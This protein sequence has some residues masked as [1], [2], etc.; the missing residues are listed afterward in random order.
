MDMVT[1]VIV[2]VIGLVV[3]IAIGAGTPWLLK[4]RQGYPFEAQIET[5]LTEYAVTAIAV[6]Y[7]MSEKTMDELGHRLAGVDKKA[8]A[9]AI[10]DML[11]P[12]IGGIPIVVVKAIVTRERFG[13]LVQNAF[14]QFEIFWGAR[15]TQLEQLYNEWVADNF[16]STPVQ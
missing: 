12:E 1:L 6:G 8:F 16:P 9:Y 2:L 14:Y 3:I 5:A 7:R 4:N 15:Q 13:Q 11:P 10:Y